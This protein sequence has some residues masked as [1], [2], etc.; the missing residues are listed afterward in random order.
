MTVSST[1][2]AILDGK[3]DGD[4]CPLLVYG[5][6]F[7]TARVVQSTSEP[8]KFNTITA[9]L[10]YYSATYQ[11]LNRIHS[12]LKTDLGKERSNDHCRSWEEFFCHL[13]LRF[14][15]YTY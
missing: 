5:P 8:L 1:D 9:T 6:R 11:Q 7:V 4:A 13:A 15:P 2:R 14:H 12:N 10:R 3:S